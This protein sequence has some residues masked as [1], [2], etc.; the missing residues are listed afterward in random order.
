VHS[1]NWSVF[2]S[3]LKEFFAANCTRNYVADERI[4]LRQVRGEI[5]FFPFVPLFYAETRKSEI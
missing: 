5:H 4:T 1:E 2:F 3:S